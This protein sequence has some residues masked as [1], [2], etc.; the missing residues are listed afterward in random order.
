LPVASALISPCVIDVA[1]ARV[2]RA[3]AVVS[4]AD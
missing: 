4:L 1:K 3:V 2:A